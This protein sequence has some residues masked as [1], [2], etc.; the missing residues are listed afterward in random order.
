M[1]PRIKLENLKLS[2]VVCG[3]NQFIGITHRPNPFDILLHL[4]RFKDTNTVAKFMIFLATKHGVNCCVSSPRQKIHDAIKM[5][6]KETGEKFHW[7]CTPSIRKTVP[8]LEP[9]IYKQID[10]C[11]EHD[12]SVCMPH[13]I[14]TD[15][16]INKEALE[17]GGQDFIK[18]GMVKFKSS[19][20]PLKTIKKM[21]EIPYPEI[22]SYIRDK[23]M[24]PG[25]STHFIETIDAVEKNNYDAPIIIQPLNMKGYMSDTHP[26]ILSK[27]IKSTKIQILNI[28]PMAAGRLRPKVA[29]EYCLNNIKKNDLLAIG[30]GKYNYLIEDATILDNYF[31]QHKGVQLKS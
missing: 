24:I 29:I 30:F 20:F 13:R 4:K 11:Y 6:E 26:E 10:W 15:L 14:Y 16:A 12:V 9:D 5:T 22:A 28:K 31:N 17:I 7:I 27:K 18:I 21:C 23:G 2:K 8:G 3:T 19:F 1:Y 25:L